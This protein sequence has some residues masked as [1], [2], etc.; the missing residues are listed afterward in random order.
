MTAPGPP[1]AD[2][3]EARTEARVC[4]AD[5]FVERAR[6]RREHLKLSQAELARRMTEQLPETWYSA[7]VAR[8]ESGQRPLRLHEAAAM[9][10]VLG[11]PAPFNEHALAAEEAASGVTEARVAEITKRADEQIAAMAERLAEAE[12]RAA[13]LENTLCRIHALADIEE[14]R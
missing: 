10:D 14:A 12:A 8:M 11:L 6:R 2:A 3:S 13:R 9:A 4:V 1:H 7:T 5:I